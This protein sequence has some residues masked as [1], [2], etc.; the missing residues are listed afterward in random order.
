M[1]N[2]TFGSSAKKTLIVVY[3]D[4]LYVNMLKKLIE[5]NDDESDENVVGVRDHSVEIVAWNEKVWLDNKKKGT[6]KGKFLF[7]GNIKGVE[8]LLQVINV[9]FNEY[10]ITFGWSGN[11]AILLANPKE[12]VDRDAFLRAF[13]AI[14]NGGDKAD[15]NNDKTNNDA[16]N[17]TYTDKYVNMLNENKNKKNPQNNDM[18]F[19]NPQKPLKIALAIGLGPV[20]S[21]AALVANEGIKKAELKRK[22]YAYGITKM[23]YDSLSDFLEQ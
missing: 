16:E 15:E 11:Q 19:T 1:F 12:I 6:I 2:E 3:E 14:Y 17:M 13:D 5:T 7:L 4:E 10:G 18:M 23:Y 21:V 8:K 22:Q 20:G 9:K